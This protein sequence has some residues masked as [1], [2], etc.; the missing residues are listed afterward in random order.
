M[1]YDL[2]SEPE[3]GI[4]DSAM[5]ASSGY[6]ENFSAHGSRFDSTHAWAPLEDSDENWI[7]ADL[8]ENRVVIAIR[9]RG[10]VNTFYDYLGYITQFKVSTSVNGA[11]WSDVVDEPGSTIVFQ[12]NSD[13]ETAVTNQMPALIVT[14]HAELTVLAFV[15]WPTMRWAFDGCP[16]TA[17]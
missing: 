10:Y 2:I 6:N 15:E 3:Y 5:T 14:R 9:T 13:A 16:V 7:S 17:N 4:P 11:A 8:G 12:G 1:T